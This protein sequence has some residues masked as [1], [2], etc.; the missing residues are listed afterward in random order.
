MSSDLRNAVEQADPDLPLDR[1]MSMT[2]VIDSKGGD[3]LF[4]RMRAS[5]PSRDLRGDRYFA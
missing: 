1:V 3:V 5:S 2:S 4:S